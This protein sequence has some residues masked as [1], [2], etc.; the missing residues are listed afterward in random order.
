[1][2]PPRIAIAA[3]TLTALLLSVITVAGQG[4]RG[5]A[6]PA[7]GSDIG[8]L[9]K[10][11]NPITPENPLPRRL[12][13]VTPLY[14][15]EAAGSGLALTLTVKATLGPQGRVDE[16]RVTGYR[17]ESPGTPGIAVLVELRPVFAK[18]ATDAVRQWIYDSPADP[19]ISLYV[20]VKFVP[21]AES[22]IVWHDALPPPVATAVASAA[23]PPPPAIPG[24]I[25]VG[26]NIAPPK[27]IKDVK[28]VYP[29]IAA[30]A[31]VTGIVIIEATIGADGRV[32]DA[33]VVRSI[34]LLD[35]AAVDAVRQWE[36]TPTL[37]NGVPT[38]IIMSVTV[39]FQLE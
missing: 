25:R 9:E 6:P 32:V 38:P 27:K 30:S 31:K 17:L 21:D 10:R 7:P 35:Q 15:S 20:Q 2:T 1:M 26:G 28:P 33:R 24:A 8:P 3:A 29:P 5:A 34:P 37:L 39:N 11:A 16:A 14:P 22:S 13:F 36:F 12:S 19:P 18:A 4:A 23:L